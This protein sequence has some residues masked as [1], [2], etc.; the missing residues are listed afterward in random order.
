LADPLGRN[1]KAL[2][3]SNMKNASIYDYST[4]DLI[5][6]ASVD[7]AKYLAQCTSPEGVVGAS[8]VLSNADIER[9]GID[10]DLSVYVL[11]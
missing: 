9:L 2:E 3:S 11:E 5:G 7:M 1:P 6:T 8:E 10:A 4:G